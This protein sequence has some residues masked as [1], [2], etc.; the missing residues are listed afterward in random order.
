MTSKYKICPNCGDHR[1]PYDIACG[2]SSETDG[3]CGYSLF[4]VPVTSNIPR[5]S[6]PS[7]QPDPSATGQAPLPPEECPNGHPI[8]VGD[9]L[10]LT[11]G[12]AIDPE[13][14]NDLPR[15]IGQWVLVE[16]LE[17]TGVGRERYTVRHSETEVIGILHL[18]TYAAHHDTRRLD[19][20]SRLA[21]ERLCGLLDYGTERDESYEVWQSNDGPVLNARSGHLEEL[22]LRE[23]V[24]QLLAALEELSGCN[25]RHG[26]IT[27]ASIA[28][29]SH[30][31]LS[32]CLTGLETADLTEFQLGQSNPPTL[33]RYIAP[34]AIVGAV[35]EASDWWSVGIVILEQLSKGDA[36]TGGNDRAFLLHVV[37]RQIELPPNLPND[38]RRLLQG[39]LTRDHMKRWGKDEVRRWL[40]GDTDIPVQFDSRQQ[41]SR[42]ETPLTLGG[43]P[44]WSGEDFSLEAA[45]PENWDEAL[46]LTENGTVA[47][48]L[49]SGSIDQQRLKLFREIIGDH[50]IDRNVRFGLGLIA[51]NADM[52]LVLRGNI[53]SPNT[54]LENSD[55]TTTLFNRYVLSA[56][57]R[58]N[59][60]AWL[61]HLIERAD[62]V[63]A[64][65][66][67]LGVGLVSERFD[68]VRLATSRPKL[69][70]SWT[71]RR[72]ISP[73]SRQPGLASLLERRTLSDEDLVLLISADD[74]AFISSAEVAGEAAQLADS[75]GLVAPDDEHLQNALARPKRQMIDDI[76]ELVG[77][78]RKIGHPDLDQWADDLRLGRRLSFSQLVLLSITAPDNWVDPPHQKYLLNV[79]EFLG[80]KI[81]VGINRGP[82]LKLLIG[83]SARR[84]DLTTLGEQTSI[85]LISNV[86]TSNDQALPLSVTNGQPREVLDKLIRIAREANLHRRE[87]GVSALVVGYPMIAF[88]DKSITGA[89]AIRMAPLALLPIQLQTGTTGVKVAFDPER[90]IELNP[91]LDRILGEA[92]ATAWQQRFDTEVRRNAQSSRD[93]LRAFEDFAR[94]E[95]NELI[96]IPTQDWVKGRTDVSLLSAG[97]LMLADF[98]SQ[99]IVSDLRGI[100]SHPLTGS[101]LESLLRIEAIEDV[102]PPPRNGA[103]DSFLIRNAD[104]SQERA[105]LG[106]RS[107]PGLK[108]E[109]PPG[110]GKSQT[111]VNIVTDCLGR[112]ETVMV[113]CE[114]QAALEVVH[115]RL[116]AVKLGHRVV[117]IENTKSDRKKL[118]EGLRDQVPQVL[119][120]RHGDLSQ[121]T[122]SRNTVADQIDE[123]ENRLGA[124]HAAVQAPH[125]SFGTS[126]REL[127]ARIAT[128]DQATHGL[129]A[130]HLR[131]ELGALEAGELQ[132][133][134]GQ[135]LG[136]LPLWMKADASNPELRAFA[137][138]DCD[139]KL[140]AKLAAQVKALGAAEEAR[141]TALTQAGDMQSLSDGA[142]HRDFAAWRA[143]NS[144]SLKSVTPVIRQDMVLWQD[145]LRKKPDATGS[146]NFIHT[147]LF[148]ASGVLRDIQPSD[149]ELVVYKPIADAND[150]MIDA[151]AGDENPF[152][153]NRSF[154]QKLNPFA[155]MKKRKML[156]LIQDL[157]LASDRATAYTVCQAATKEQI[158][159][160]IRQQCDGHYRD[161]QMT[162]YTA[163][164][165]ASL[166]EEVEITIARLHPCLSVSHKLD[167]SPWPAT[168]WNALP[169]SDQDWAL[170]FKRFEAAQGALAARTIVENAVK[171]L[172][173][174][175]K[176]EWQSLILSDL[177]SCRP[178]SF[179]A[180][181]LERA[182]QDISVRQAFLLSPLTELARSVFKT[183]RT[184]RSLLL[185]LKPRQQDD[186]I[187]AMLER[188]AALAWAEHLRTGNPVLATQ[189]A[190]IEADVSRLDAVD[191]QMRELNTNLLSIVGNQGLSPL[192]AW[193]AVW[194]YS[195]ANALRLRQFFESSRS[196]GLMKVRP[197]WLVNPDV[198][199]R[200]FPLEPGLFDVAIF[201]EASQMRVEY[202]V[203]A[204][205]RAKRAVVSGDSKQLPPTRFFGQSIEDDDEELSRGSTDADAEDVNARQ[206]RARSRR[207]IKDCPDL[208][209]LSEGVLTERSLGVHYRSQ[210]RELIA[211]SNAAYYRGNLS[212]PIRH[213]DADILRDRPIEVH[214]IDGIYENQTNPD[215]ARAIVDRLS[216]L[217]KESG[218]EGPTTGVV[219][220]N[221]KQAEL[222]QEGLQD[223]A[224]RD[225]GFRAALEREQMRTEDG[226]DVSLF[227]RN[228]E[229]VQ[230][231]E[232]DV[233]L[234]STTFGVNPDGVFRRSFGALVQEGGERRL[235]VAITRA[236]AKV[237]IMTS[238]P[239][240][241]ISDYLTRQGRPT[242]ARDYLQA[243]MRYAELI[244]QGSFGAAADLLDKFKHDSGFSADPLF[245]DQSKAMAQALQVILSNA[246]F[247]SELRP[248]TGIFA[249]DLVVID[250]DTGAYC[251]AVEIDAPNHPLLDT[252]KARDI[253]R[254]NL[255]AGLGLKVHRI[256]SAAWAND[257][258]SSRARFLT[259]VR[260]ATS[261]ET[262]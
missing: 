22:A 44:V 133:L 233:I 171:G 156:R 234:F 162:P 140:Q 67:D 152:S 186:A 173:N 53:Q 209:A 130:P 33:T 31:P 97:A 214:H 72:A 231:D 89:G 43:R 226:E 191:G 238:M 122:R 79:L 169:G 128:L 136:V 41:S 166:R 8:E 5:P 213:P 114:K 181:P 90:D 141:R 117:R 9:S 245:T 50:R 70:S 56:L 104:P 106:A 178:A 254:P 250:P 189:P 220:F 165:A 260:E 42:I 163:S 255:L 211:F 34:E 45:T 227:V 216:E 27:P 80:K 145:L 242:K 170:A 6:M 62:R 229:S 235:N 12:E 183:A 239:T 246:G 28:V 160:R 120:G 258:N 38:F 46:T 69:E 59:S 194:K 249:I 188:E 119:E 115:K 77:P 215:E 126:Y 124:Y 32:I 84:M 139:M 105:I 11:C 168:F 81:L 202:A 193:S 158:F 103:A 261:R 205:Y 190:Q 48:W 113:V 92:T 109:G 29:R 179:E 127:A 159:R 241:D 230:G 196:L 93:V 135:C 91:V 55:S 224:A 138:F 95:D 253:W 176:P 240:D 61:V 83:R 223:R 259:A 153:L 161:L 175:T 182:A 39:L 125:A 7:P 1:P 82:L 37:A 195:G 184:Q 212:I 148:K 96:P 65:A 228:V 177:H 14:S 225:P 26:A 201:D 144:S 10:C 78:F 217:W 60:H 25:L 155:A 164:D 206:E 51:L 204:L 256:H 180:A 167:S 192:R 20:I 30:T 19:A 88:E 221:L 24:S 100:L 198:A 222:I 172:S 243:Y 21:S 71:A 142:T 57:K 232:R 54:L 52:P 99:A 187:R 247:E 107:A 252:A 237:I 13:R 134:I 248:L 257:P 132:S 3:R 200:I 49:A 244:D 143:T 185:S 47:T 102:E 174:W 85:N 149:S 157:G 112:G 118:L 35:S 36:F 64:Q 18:H 111:I 203:P 210:Y 94:V 121:T 110:T 236:R 17:E 116:R 73:D 146:A 219:T 137:V 208:L 15:T 131:A 98:P 108:L 76:D 58:L 23:L 197:V 75:V 63:K 150:D 68:I 4:D 251:L 16:Q 101:C 87:T 199:S 123:L 207:H 218:P 86:L 154:F 151:L 2:N 129:R 147:E 40:K 262:A 66:E 74:L